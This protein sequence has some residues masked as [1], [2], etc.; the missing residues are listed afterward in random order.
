MELAQPIV[1]LQVVIER[2]SLQAETLGGVLL[3]VAVTKRL[4]E[5]L[6]ASLGEQD[7]RPNVGD[8]SVLQVALQDEGDLRGSSLGAAITLFS[9]VPFTLVVIF[10]TN[11][12]LLDPALDST[13]AKARELLVRWGNL[14]AV[15]SMLGLVSLVL[16][17][18]SSLVGM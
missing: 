17:V 1:D 18:L 12:Q 11:K 2:G 16:S 10:P 3:H 13:S 15:R 8:A 9:V 7:R 5:L 4:P 6:V 14:H